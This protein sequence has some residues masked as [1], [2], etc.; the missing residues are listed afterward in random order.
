MFQDDVIKA[1]DY[2]LPRQFKGVVEFCKIPGKES[3]V[4]FFPQHWLN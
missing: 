2:V 4:P 1:K 3:N